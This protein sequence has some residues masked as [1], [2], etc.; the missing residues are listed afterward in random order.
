MSRLTR[1]TAYLNCQIEVGGVRVGIYLFRISDDQYIRVPHH[2]DR[3]GDHDPHNPSKSLSFFLKGGKFRRYKTKIYITEPPVYLLKNSRGMGSLSE[4]KFTFIPT[5]CQCEGRG[6]GLIASTLQHEDMS[7]LDRLRI[8]GCW[9]VDIYGPLH[10]IALRFKHERI[11]QLQ[12]TVAFGTADWRLWCDI[13][14]YYGSSEGLSEIVNSYS[15]MR[16]S[17]SGSSAEEDD[18]RR[19]ARRD[20]MLDRATEKL[21]DGSLANIAIKKVIRSGSTC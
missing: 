7:D 21:Q 9:A 2:I 15:G 12:F 1:L 13:E 6:F 20:E 10:V 14:P 8:S 19:S 3:W 5:Y 18:K 16:E 4:R 17:P 11:S